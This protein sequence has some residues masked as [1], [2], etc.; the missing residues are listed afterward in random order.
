MVL[1]SHVFPR[2]IGVDGV[3]AMHSLPFIYVYDFVDSCKESIR[4]ECCAARHAR[5]DNEKR[6]IYLV[7]VFRERLW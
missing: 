7:Y 5:Y 6:D 4:A 2:R 1:Y 3:A